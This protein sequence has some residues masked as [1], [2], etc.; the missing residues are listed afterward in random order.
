MCIRRHGSATDATEAT[1]TVEHMLFSSP[2][3]SPALRI[4]CIFGHTGEI[5]QLTTDVLPGDVVVLTGQNG[6]GKSTLIDTLA[7]EL[8]PCAGEVRVRHRGDGVLLDPAAPAAAGTVIRIADPTFFPDLTLGEHVEILAR[9]TGVTK[10]ALL[11]DSAA[12]EVWDLPDTLPSRLSSGQRQRAHLGLQLAVVAVT[13]APVVVLDE[14]ERHLDAAWTRVLCGE[15]R[16]AGSGGAA[17]VVASH[18][19]AVTEV[20][21][22]VVAL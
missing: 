13:A 7:G 15:L 1:D 10:D 11:A 8:A 17:V 4:D 16:R 12:W 6:A 20:A 19:P 5:G 3:I 21:D 2:D 18:S 9:R 22:R 14:P